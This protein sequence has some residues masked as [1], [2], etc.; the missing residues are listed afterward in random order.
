MLFVPS[1][2]EFCE[3]VKERYNPMDG[4]QPI[5]MIDEAVQQLKRTPFFQ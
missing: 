5:A 2:E 1:Q 4:Q 3:H